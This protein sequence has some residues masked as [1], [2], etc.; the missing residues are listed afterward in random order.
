MLFMSFVFHDF[1]SVHCCFV[2]TCWERADLL[3][4]F[5]MF[6]CAFVT[7]PRGILW[8][9]II[10]IPE[11][12]RLSHIVLVFFTFTCTIENANIVRQHNSGH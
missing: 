4:L 8:Y 2:V 10:S 12:C 3:S 5:V 7:F 9:L 11:R 6:N 1:A